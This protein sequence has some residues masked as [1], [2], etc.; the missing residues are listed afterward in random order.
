MSHQTHLFAHAIK[1]LSKTRDK[2]DGAIAGAAAA[3]VGIPAA[4]G[5]A[6]L[7]LTPVGWALALGGGAAA[8]AAYVARKLK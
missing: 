2:G 3:S 8:G 7:A 4:L 1:H 5:V 6:G